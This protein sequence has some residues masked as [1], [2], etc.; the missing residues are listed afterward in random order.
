MSKSVAERLNSLEKELH[1]LRGMVE[2]LARENHN[3][4][5]ASGV[6]PVNAIG[7]VECEKLV[8]QD[9]DA[10]PR[11]SCVVGPDG[12]SGVVLHD[13]SDNNRLILG[14]TSQGEP[15][16]MMFDNVGEIRMQIGISSDDDP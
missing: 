3:L 2:R 7:A 9:Q 13:R 16:I 1:D 6:S 11:I 5:R 15:I 10:I 8:I 14:Q 12:T 4:K